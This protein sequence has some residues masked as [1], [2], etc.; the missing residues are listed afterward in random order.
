[1]TCSTLRSET[2]DRLV[3]EG[4][5]EPCLVGSYLYA[6]DDIVVYAIYRP[7]LVVEVKLDAIRVDDDGR[8]VNYD[9][10]GLKV[11]KMSDDASYEYIKTMYGRINRQIAIAKREW[12]K[13]K[14][15]DME[16]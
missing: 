13:R 5:I 14:L 15:G 1:M 16:K 12:V 3:G 11:N 8:V 7:L 9:V 2:I 10:F 6:V 4:I